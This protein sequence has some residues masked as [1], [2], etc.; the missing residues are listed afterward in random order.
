MKRA[1]ATV[2]AAGYLASGCG[3]ILNSNTAVV[4]G[5]PG[6]RVNGAPVP[7]IINQKTSNQVVF[8]DGR[9]CIITSSASAGYIIA[10]ILLT[11]LLGVIIDAA[12]GG[13][14]VAD[15]DACPG[16]VVD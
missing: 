4:N 2:V 9:T 3:A 7:A 5:P 14:K 10:D 6:T 8:P 12:T 13:W 15:A 16:I 1:L 11:A